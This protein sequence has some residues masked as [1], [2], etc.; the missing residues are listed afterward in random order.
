LNIRDENNVTA[1]R[2]STKGLKV[3]PSYRKCWL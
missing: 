2:L 1:L 3:S